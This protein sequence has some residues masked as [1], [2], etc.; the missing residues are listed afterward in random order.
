MKGYKETIKFWDDVFQVD[1]Q[2]DPTE[3]LSVKDIDSS[4]RWVANGSK[5]ILDFGCGNGKGLLRAVHLCSGKGTGIDISSEAIRVAQE[6][7]ERAELQ[8]VRFIE[9]GLE[10]LYNLETDSFDAGILFNVLDNLKPDDAKSLLNEFQRVIRP[11]GKLLIKLNDYIDP[12]QLEEWNAEKL[13]DNFYREESGL[14]FWNLTD[15]DVEDLLSAQFEIE[16]RED[17]RFEEQDQ[18]NRLYYLKITSSD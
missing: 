14:Y 18:V 7:S 15:D 12:E 8:E 5:N 3:P 17:I 16:K 4:L 13:Y 11:D 9:G 2:F 1:E 10:E 6:H